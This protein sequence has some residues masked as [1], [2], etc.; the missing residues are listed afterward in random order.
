MQEHTKLIS[1]GCA[2]KEKKQQ[3]TV[4]LSFTVRCVCCIWFKL[5]KKHC[6]KRVTKMSW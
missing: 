1:T 6:N 2:L 4:L 3:L 5:R